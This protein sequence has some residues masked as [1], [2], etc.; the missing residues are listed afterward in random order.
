MKSVGFWAAMLGVCVLVYAGGCAKQQKLA[1][2]FSPGQ[3][4]TYKVV[5][6]SVKDYKFEQPSINQTKQQ[7]TLNQV[8]V[9]FDQKIVSVEPSED[10]KALITIKEVKYLAKN[11]KGTA[12]DFDSTKEADNKNAMEDL[13]GQSYIIKISPAGDVVA[14]EDVQKA[15]E[16][17]KGDTL[18]QKTAQSLLADDAI[19]QRH[20]I[21]ALPEK[22]GSAAVGTTW[23]KVKAGPAGMLT[24]R[25]YEEVYTLKQVNQESGQ[26]VAVVTMEARPSTAKAPNMPKEEAKGMGFF[27]KMFDNKETYTGKMQMDLSTGQV[28][29]YNEKLR[30]EWVAVEPAEEVKSDKGPDVLT[31]GFTYTY[32]I[33]KMK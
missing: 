5:T 21:F 11:P 32:S 27:E 10:A 1:L 25:S 23:S 33:E 22:D 15:R 6:E 12:I 24:P 26:K 2:K 8:E 29:S 19:K 17:V 16:A 31:M 28:E 18:E 30:S 13:I 14:V 7:Q 20:T 3:T 4:S 9:V